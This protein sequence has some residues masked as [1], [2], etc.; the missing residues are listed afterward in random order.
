MKIRSC[1]YKISGIYIIVNVLNNKRYVGSSKDVY[2]R[3]HKH[4]SQLKNNI[5][6]NPHLQN[7]WNKNES[8]LRCYLIE[9]CQT[10][11]LNER[12]QYWIDKISP[13]YNID[14]IVFPRVIH[15]EETKKKISALSKK[16]WK[17]GKFKNVQTPIKVYKLVEEYVG[18]FTS[19]KDASEELGIKYRSIQQSLSG[20]HKKHNRTHEYIFYYK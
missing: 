18:E 15:S 2:H 20:N 11:I 19:L 16:M 3:L 17:E 12:E 14:R 9:E 10:D 1:Y 8:S 13:E 6:S 7:S 5:H 4:K